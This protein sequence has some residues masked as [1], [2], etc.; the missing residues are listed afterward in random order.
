MA[1]LRRAALLLLGAIV[2][3]A[4]VGFTVGVT[5]V[6]AAA[7]DA[8]TLKSGSTGPD[9]GTTATGG[10]ALAV[11]SMSSDPSVYVEADQVT[12]GTVEYLSGRRLLHGCHS[13]SLTQKALVKYGTTAGIRTSGTSGT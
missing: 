12:E 7:V 9:P 13:T 11:A 8:A 2:C 10:D 3:S 5:P 6:G 4:A 1:G